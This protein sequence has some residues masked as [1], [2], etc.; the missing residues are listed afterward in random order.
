VLDRDA[1]AARASA[2]RERQ[3]AHFDVASW[4]ARYEKIYRDLLAVREPNARP[5]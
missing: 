2:A 4:S 5:A 1:A 3:R